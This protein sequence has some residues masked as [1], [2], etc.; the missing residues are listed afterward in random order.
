MIS[1]IAKKYC[2]EAR[3][4]EL[5]AYQLFWQNL[6]NEFIAKNETQAKKT[7]HPG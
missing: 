2:E 5:A 1:E 7:T 4:K 6:I 3:A